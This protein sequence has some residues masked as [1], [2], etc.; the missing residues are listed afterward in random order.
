MLTLPEKILFAIALLITFYVAYKVI[1]RIIQTTKRGTGEVDWNLAKQRF[2]E[3]FV[4]VAALLPTFNL[5]VGTSI[6]HALVAWGF[7]YYMFVNTGDVLDGFI[8]D[9][10]FLGQGTLGNFYRLGADIFSV[11]VLFGMTVLM[12]RR[13]IINP[14]ILST[15]E[16]VFLNDKI[17]HSIRRDSAIVGAFI[18]THV[19]SR[20]LSQSFKIA[21]EGGDPWQP[22]GSYV[23]NLWSG[24]SST[25][26]IIGEHIFFWLA[27]GTIFLLSHIFSTQS[28]CIFLLS[29]STIYSSQKAMVLVYSINLISRTKLSSNSGHLIWRTFPGTKFLTAMLVSCASV[30]RKNVLLIILGKSFPQQRWRL[31]KGIS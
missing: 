14:P 16:D 3:V 30:A 11:F 20:F 28:I 25:G 9:F 22:F 4:K 2:F 21:S 10:H 1:L 17:R 6:I 18:I 15:R 12:I 26:L 24:F 5:R 23:A 8:P 31:T 29:H 7:L 19:G 13:F 27:L